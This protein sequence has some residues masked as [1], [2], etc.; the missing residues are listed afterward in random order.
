[1]SQF[2][3][4]QPPPVK[5]ELS[6]KEGRSVP[7]KNLYAL[8]EAAQSLGGISIW[9]LRKH[10]SNRNVTVVRLGRRVFVRSEEMERIRQ[11]GLP[12]LRGGACGVPHAEAVRNSNTKENGHEQPADA[13]R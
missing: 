12:S 11:E 5:S 9:T 2:S 3:Y 13:T 4:G 10:V 8:K 6:R 7:I 1:M